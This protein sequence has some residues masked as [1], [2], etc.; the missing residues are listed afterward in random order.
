MTFKKLT[1]HMNKLVFSLLSI[2]PWAVSVKA[3]TPLT[4]VLPAVAYRDVP[5]IAAQLE[6]DTREFS[7]EECTFLFDSQ[8]G[9]DQ[10]FAFINAMGWG[11]TTK[12]EMYIQFLMKQYTLKHEV[13]D[14]ILTWRGFQPL[15]YEPAAKLKA[16]DYSCL[17]Y[18][19]AYGN[20]QAPLRAYYCAYHAVDMKPQSEAAAYI[21]G[22]ILAQFYMQNDEC[23]VYKV[24]EG[25]R[26]FDGF[27][28]DRLREKAVQNC[29][30]FINK[31][32]DACAPNEIPV[33]MR[34]LEPQRMVDKKNYVD[35]V[36]LSIAPPDWDGESK[37]TIVKVKIKNKGSVSSIETNA[38]L[39]DLDI[40][41][42]EA[43]KRKFSK[44][45]IDA[46]AENN[47]LAT[48]ENDSY[49]KKGIDSDPDWKVFV[50]IP[51]MQPGE[52]IEL[53]FEL[54]EIWIYDPNCEIEVMLDA[55]GN[56]EE[57]DEKNNV[58]DFV[59]RG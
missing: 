46:I 26:T 16:D 51:I 48:D 9:L 21:Y 25:I 13:F 12:V 50:K 19:Q 45:W 18:L 28:T 7:P 5:V 2:F 30:D 22:L 44:L 20:Y 38:V 47:N 52:E 49:T 54:K 40:T 3:D 35:L 41:A 59:G 6:G 4:A 58:M 37:K 24:M 33:Y 11:D 14:S 39:T 56:I 10:K 34:P 27:K 31:F 8:T 17:A 32:K 29:F 36:V 15:A 55:D 42:A 1:M 53:V 23:S 57:K 43:K